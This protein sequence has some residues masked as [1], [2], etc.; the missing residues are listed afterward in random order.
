MVSQ[1]KKEIIFWTSE[2]A[3][4]KLKSSQNYWNMRPRILQQK[5]KWTKVTK[6]IAGSF[7]LA[8]IELQTTETSLLLPSWQGVTSLSLFT[9][10]SACWHRGSLPSQHGSGIRAGTF[11]H[12]NA[13][14]VHLQNEPSVDRSNYRGSEILHRRRAAAIFNWQ[15]A[16]FLV[17]FWHLCHL[18]VV[19][20]I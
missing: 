10:G 5:Q 8:K 2:P 19:C 12:T 14:S 3:P 18:Q 7:I 17:F 11:T 9:L 1:K 13:T 6:N 16:F 4:L 20:Q 15:K